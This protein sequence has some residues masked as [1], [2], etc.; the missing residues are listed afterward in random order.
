V[1]FATYL[2]LFENGEAFVDPKVLPV[3][4]GD[5]ISCPRMGDFMGCNVHLGLVSGDY[6]RR[7]KGK[8]WVLHGEEF[9]KIEAQLGNS[10]MFTDMTRYGLDNVF[11]SLHPTLKG[12]SP[13]D[14]FSTIPY[15][16]GF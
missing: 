8:K 10:S 4:A 11:S 5:V 14:A 12:A 2:S 9:M 16:K 6:G 1:D 3:L 13:D 7:G 15:E